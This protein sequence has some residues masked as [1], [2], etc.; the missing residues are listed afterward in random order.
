MH[1]VLQL[2]KD[3]CGNVAIAGVPSAGFVVEVDGI[4]DDR[5]VIDPNYRVTQRYCQ[6][7]PLLVLIEIESKLVDL[8]QK[9]LVS[10]C[11]STGEWNV[12]V[13][14]EM[15]KPLRLQVHLSHLARLDAVRALPRE[16]HLLS[17]F[18]NKEKSLALWRMQDVRLN[19]VSL[20]DASMQKQIAILYDAPSTY[21]HPLGRVRVY[22]ANNAII[23]TYC[24]LSI[25]DGILPTEVLGLVQ[26]Y[27]NWQRFN[28]QMRDKTNAYNSHADDERY[29]YDTIV[30]EASDFNLSIPIARDKYDAPIQME[31]DMFVMPKKID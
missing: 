22:G 4:V 19:A 20:Y 15:V 10:F 23:G 9:L 27:R 6:E 12:E 1:Q 13:W 3:H 30:N 14:N 7:T 21:P 28:D 25:T 8:E 11:Q 29:E 17:T 16:Q 26:A 5:G 31:F 18:K 2:T 24:V